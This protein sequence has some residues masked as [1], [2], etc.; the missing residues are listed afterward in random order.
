VAV[1]D[2]WRRAMLANAE[3]FS[4]ID[5]PE[6]VAVRVVGWEIN[7]EPDWPVNPDPSQSEGHRRSRA[8]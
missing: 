1:T 8:G 2:S 7:R 5:Y 3:A 6:G 4:Q